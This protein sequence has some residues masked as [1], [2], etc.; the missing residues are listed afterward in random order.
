MARLRDGQ[1]GCDARSFVRTLGAQLLADSPEE[2]R[3]PICVRLAAMNK[4][5]DD[6]GA[7]FRSFAKRAVALDTAEPNVG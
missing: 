4:M 2:M 7:A 5:L 1:V 3:S 6:R